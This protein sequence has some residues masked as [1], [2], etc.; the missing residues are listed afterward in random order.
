[1][2][3]SPS[4]WSNLGYQNYSEALIPAFLYGFVYLTGKK[5]LYFGITCSTCLKT[6]VSIC[7][8]E[9][10]AYIADSLW[11]SALT[12]ISGVKCELAT[13]YYGTPLSL[14]VNKKTLKRLNIHCH[15]NMSGGVG[16]LT[17]EK[18]RWQVETEEED[19][20]ELQSKGKWVSYGPLASDTIGMCP[21]LYWLDESQNLKLA[22]VENDKGLKL[23]P[24]YVCRSKLIQRIEDFC[25]KHY[26]SE[27]LTEPGGDEFQKILL[28]VDFIKILLTRNVDFLFSADDH[29]W[30]EVP[31][32][33]STVLVPLQAEDQSECEIYHTPSNIVSVFSFL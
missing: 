29:P 8:G 1:M 30:Y 19:Y 23:Y 6:T 32:F 17:Y 33:R 27:C 21:F 11:C 13:R 25:W 16:S 20:P 12:E 24:R 26:Y 18:L 9:A 3:T 15:S 14:P 2:I 22:Q 5:G 31:L 28:K 7:D 4:S 10:I